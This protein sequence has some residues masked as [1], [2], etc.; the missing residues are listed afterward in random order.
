MF[1][2]QVKKA[3]DIFEKKYPWAQAL[4]IFDNA[5]SHEKKPDDSLNPEKMN[6]SDGGR[7]P[8]MRDTQWNGN[9]QKITLD[10]GTQ[11]GVLTE[12]GVDTR[13]DECI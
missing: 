13:G 11:K 12:R 4:L 10:D 7:Q 8:R 2:V 3:I 6:I 9:V 5:P 1:V